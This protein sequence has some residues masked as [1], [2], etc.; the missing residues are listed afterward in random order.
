[1]K[2]NRGTIFILA[3]LVIIVALMGITAANPWKAKLRII[4][5][6]GD[7]IF[8]NLYDMETGLKKYYLRISGEPEPDPTATPDADF[9]PTP[10]VTPTV[11]PTPYLWEVWVEN[12]TSMYTIEREI[13]YARI[14]ACGV[15]MDGTMDL[16][17][18]LKLNI[19]PCY[20]MFRYTDPRYLGEPSMEKPNWFRAPGMSLWRFQ[21]VLPKIDLE[22]YPNLPNYVPEREF[23]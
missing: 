6:T 15:V 11:T 21:Y 1:M 12:N 20:S 16:T 23:K 14:V 13:Y 19:T 10:G 4:N 9:K 22:T 2:T 17:R 3:I 5:Q 8:L 7:D 18:N